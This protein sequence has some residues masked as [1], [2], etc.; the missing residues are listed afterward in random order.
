MN[1]LGLIF[2]IC[3]MIRRDA[4]Q[5]I[6]LLLQEFPAVAILGP[7]QVG[8]TTLVKSL[9]AKLKREVV[10]I[11][12]ERASDQRKLADPEIFFEAN[13][14]RLVLLDEVQMMPQLFAALRP[15]IDELRKPGRFLLTGS[16]S[17]ELVKGV[18]ESL[19]GRIAYTELTPVNLSESKRS[20]YGTQ[21]HWFRGG[22]PLALTAKDD[23]AF[24]RWADSFIRSYVERDLSMMFGVNLP[25]VLIRNFWEMLANGTGT[26][27]N[28]ENY[29]R[30]LGISGPSVKRY[31]DYMEGAFLIR[32][33][34][35]WFA[36]VNK[37]IIKSPKVY[38]RDS[39]IVHSLC[40]ISS[41][42]ELQGNIVVGGSWEG[43]VIEEIIRHIPA[44]VRPFYYR[45]QHGAEADLILV[46]GM[47]PVACIEIKYSKAPVLKAGFYQCIKDL[48]TPNNWVIYSGEDSYTGREGILYTSLT[49]TLLNLITKL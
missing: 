44:T 25:A 40:G 35:P 46:K 43:Y 6:D 49:N 9:A 30:A 12:L 1:L 7:R 19:A 17:P 24:R 26:I 2:Y 16:A 38:V 8:K 20:H 34:Q 21:R 29:A 36:N 48:Q 4:L 10:Y 41:A 27:L 37:R 45:T 11:D 33:L 39:G 31:L 18:S 13:R 23:A 47:K 15:E 32:R 14:N 3:V 28:I 42:R 22:Y 5:N